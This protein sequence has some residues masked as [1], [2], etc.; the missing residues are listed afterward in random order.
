METQT[1]M[2][3]EIFERELD[4]VE[5]WNSLFVHK[6]LNVSDSYN[7]YHS[8]KI[9]CDMY[10]PKHWNGKNKDTVRIVFRAFNNFR[11]YR[12][13]DY[14]DL[15]TNWKFCMKHYFNKLPDIIS[16]EWLYEH[17]YIPF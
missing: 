11:M 7:W 13:F 17:G 10:H 4:I 9:I 8:D 1:K 12:D 2:V 3:E 15:E 14:Y 16:V 5:P 6:L